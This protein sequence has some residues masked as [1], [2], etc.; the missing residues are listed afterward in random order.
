MPDLR[1]DPIERAITDLAAGRAVVGVDDESRENEGDL[2]F[3]AALA[4][5]RLLAFTVRHSSGVV[6]TP[7]EGDRLD[8]L[9]LPQMTSANN[10]AM[11]TAF[12][13]SVDPAA[14][15]TTGISAT[16]RGTTISLLAAPTSTADDLVRPGHVF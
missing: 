13:I 3:A 6:C 2:V 1:L 16:D 7:M 11:R 9:A 14:G 15:V 12:T 5:P 10:E 4:T 8:R